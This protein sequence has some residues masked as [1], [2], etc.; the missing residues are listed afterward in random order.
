M[1]QTVSKV[2]MDEHLRL[3]L[4]RADDFVVYVNRWC[5]LWQK[6]A[7]NP[8]YDSD[9]HVE[10][11]WL[12]DLATYRQYLER[13]FQRD[14]NSP[15]LLLLGTIFGKWT[16]SGRTVLVRNAEE[17]LGPLASLVRQATRRLTA[18]SA[19][20]DHAQRADSGTTLG[21]TPEWEPDPPDQPPPSH[22][23][24]PSSDLYWR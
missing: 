2:L 24:T 4:E 20:A 14:N 17:D 23:A 13:I 22:H 19:Q 3:D 11:R 10:K 1:P 12:E 18:K 21:S 7:N 9:E 5:D 16:E 6:R 15:G 8:R